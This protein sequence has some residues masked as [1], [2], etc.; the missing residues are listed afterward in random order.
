M[1]H[2]FAALFAALV[3]ALSA[4][5]AV[6]SPPADGLAGAPAMAYCTAADLEDRYDAA[7]LAQL[8]GDADGQAVS[9]DKIED[10][11]DDAASEIETA[12]VTQYGESLVERDLDSLRVLNVTGAYL[13]L[14]SW[15]P[16]SV[17]DADSS[18]RL[19]LERWDAK[20]D[21]VAAGKRKVLPDAA[22]EPDADADGVPDERLSFQ[23]APRLF[24]RQRTAA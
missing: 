3:L 9:Q 23:A 21:A 7:T 15:A 12:V 8:T 10:A 2:T 1:R 11:I 20:L 14:R 6:A 24:G 17:G 22:L 5:P 16:E 4:M 18:L 13:M 19:D